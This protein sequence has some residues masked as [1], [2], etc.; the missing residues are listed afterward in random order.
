MP[1]TSSPY[2][3]RLIISARS[4]PFVGPSLRLLFGFTW[5]SLLWGGGLVVAGL[6]HA[7]LR[8]GY[9]V[10]PLVIAIVAS[11]FHLYSLIDRLLL[12]AL[13]GLWLATALAARNIYRR[14]TNRAWWAFVI[15]SLIALGGTNVYR[16]YLS[17]LRFSD[18]R[19][20]ADLAV[21]HPFQAHPLAVP[22]LDYYLRIHPQARRSGPSEG[23]VKECY[24]LYDVTT[25]PAV[26]ES[27]SRDSISA[28][29]RGCKVMKIELYRA[30]ALQLECP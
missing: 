17:P 25:A 9:L 29:L 10:L 20:L 23:T 14:L 16:Y 19:A 15:I 2:P 12:F 13:P 24:R 22:V 1:P 3:A 5:V 21:S 18:G 27:I 8:Y 26:R 6:L 4:G 30:S 28:T 7:R 11:A